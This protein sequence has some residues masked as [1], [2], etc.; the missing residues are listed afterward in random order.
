MEVIGAMADGRRHA[1]LVQDARAADFGAESRPE[2][3]VAASGDDGRLV[4]ELDLGHEQPRIAARRRVI[5]R[6]MIIGSC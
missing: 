4:I 2:I 6:R 5:V 3:A 1:L